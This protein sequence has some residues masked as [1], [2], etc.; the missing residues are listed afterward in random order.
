MNHEVQRLAE[1]YGW[2]EN[3]T[4]GGCSALEKQGDGYHGMITDEA[5]VPTDASAIC[6]LGIYRTDEEHTDPHIQFE[7]PDLGAAMKLFDMV[8]FVPPIPPATTL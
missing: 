7:C 2:G 8:S 5:E 1:H 6:T 4:G 3:M